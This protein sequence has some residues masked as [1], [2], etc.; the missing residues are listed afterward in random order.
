MDK[1]ISDSW[2]EH[3]S[4]EF[5]K[6]YFKQL[7]QFVDD[8]YQ[9]NEI[10]PPQ[11][12]IFKAFNTCPFEDIKVVILGQDPYHG[13]NQANGLAFSV[14]DKMRFPPS[15]RNIYKELN[16]DL[17]IPISSKGNLEDWAKQGVLLI[18]A[19]LTVKANEA[20]SHQHKG[21]EEFTDAAI[22][23]LSEKREKLVFILWGSY[24][25]KKGLQIDRKKHFILKSAH[26][27]PLSAHRGFFKSQPFSQTNTY[28][29]EQGLEPI[30]WEL[31]SEEEQKTLGL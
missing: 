29:K 24:A 22:K 6:G 16:K 3:L 26:P 14:N 13:P 2:K 10:Y 17:N 7:E 21:W 20:G 12:L 25:H 9:E 23:A 18:N 8:E 28:L 1:N 27:S 15:L 4:P 11:E 31:K 30:D 5:D 19:T